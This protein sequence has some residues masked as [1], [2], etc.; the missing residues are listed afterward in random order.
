MVEDISF[1]LHIDPIIP[2]IISASAYIIMGVLN[3]YLA[4]QL[5]SKVMSPMRLLGAR[6]RFL[7]RRIMSVYKPILTTQIIFTVHFIVEVVTRIGQSIS[8]DE[9][10]VK[11]RMAASTWEMISIISLLL[12]FVPTREFWP[13][14]FDTDFELNTESINLK[15]TFAEINT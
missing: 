11:F 13:T 9:G 3:Y 1:F 15:E 6:S 4:K 5:L 2:N 8:N 12:I 10:Q 14:N 7:Y